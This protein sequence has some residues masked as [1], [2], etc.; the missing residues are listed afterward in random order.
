M[1][2]QHHKAILDYEDVLDLNVYQNV[3]LPF[4]DNKETDVYRLIRQER[5]GH[6]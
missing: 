3:W 1:Q 2:K 6:Y 4:G 5:I